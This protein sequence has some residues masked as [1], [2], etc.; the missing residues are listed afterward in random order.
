MRA[1]HIKLF[2]ELGRLWAQVIGIALVMAAGVATMIIG[3]G[4]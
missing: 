1:L 2:R 4:N 3:V